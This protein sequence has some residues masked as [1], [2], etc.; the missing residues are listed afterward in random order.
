MN[1]SL[2]YVEGSEPGYTRRRKGKTWQYLTPDGRVL[3][4]AR[5]IARLNAIALPPAYTD[6][7]FARDAQAHL[8]ATGIDARGRKQYRY[9]PEF[10]AQCEEAK[11]TGCLAFGAA[12]PRIRTAVDRDLRRR[13]LSRDRVIAAVIRLLDMGKVRVGNRAYARHNRSF[14]ATTLRNRHVTIAGARIELDYVGKSGIRHRIAIEDRRLARIIK[15]CRDEPGQ[16]LF[17]YRD[18]DQ[19]RA[20]T[21]GDVNDWLRRNAGNFTAKNFRTWGASTIAFGM[22][23]QAHGQMRIT[24]LLEEVAQRL[25][26]TP[27]VARK[28]YVHP[29]LIAATHHPPEGYAWRL[30]APSR[31]HSAEERGLL[32]FLRKFGATPAQSA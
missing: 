11:F 5:T 16:E 10:R 20:V 25:G 15:R 23:A 14:G 21:S 13:D 6:A 31:W 9:H 24:P 3:R 29:A 4:S 32:A 2:R 27:A 22:L 12:L 26:N 30:P 8:Q 19:L 17:Q 18:H 7:W 1:S 28:S